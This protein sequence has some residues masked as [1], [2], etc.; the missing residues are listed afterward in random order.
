LPK[1]SRARDERAF[2]EVAGQS[3]ELSLVE[4]AEER[5]LLE[6]VSQGRHPTILTSLSPWTKLT[7]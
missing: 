2:P 6:V 4:A 3:L 7:E 5:N 1:G